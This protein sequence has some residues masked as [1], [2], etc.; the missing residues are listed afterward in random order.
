[1]GLRKGVDYD[2]DHEKLKRGEESSDD[3]DDHQD[4]LLS[5]VLKRTD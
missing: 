1:M 3:V 2:E 5:W 4:Y